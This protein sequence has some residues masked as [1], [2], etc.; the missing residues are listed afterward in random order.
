MR[1]LTQPSHPVTEVGHGFIPDFAVV[2]NPVLRQAPVGQ[3][4]T[5]GTM[6]MSFS[7][8]LHSRSLATPTEL[9]TILGGSIFIGHKDRSEILQP[10]ALS[11][12]KYLL[13]AWCER[14][15]SSAEFMTP[16][17]RIYKH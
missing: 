5:H 7:P 6:C 9:Q 13:V 1:A 3:A 11:H 10:E 4:S 15:G 2:V 16:R 17:G 8:C 14:R 12:W